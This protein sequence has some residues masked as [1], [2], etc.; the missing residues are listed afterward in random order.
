MARHRT[1]E[2]IVVG[3][4]TAGLFAGATAA[5]AGFDVVVLERKPTEEVGAIACGDAIKGSSAFPDVIDRDRLR[6][7]AFANTEIRRGVFEA[8]ETRMDVSLPTTGVV[9]DRKRY[10]EILADEAHRQGATI[11]YDTV[12][13]DVCQSDGVVRGVEA[14]RDGDPVTYRAPITIDATG[15]LSVLQDKADLSPA[16]F[17]TNVDYTQFCSAYREVIELEEPVDW[18]DA[19][20]FKPTAELGYLWYF[21][22]TPTRI[23]VGLGFR[24]DK[25][26]MELVDELKRDVRANSAFVGATVLNKAGAALPTRRPFDSAVAPGFMAVGDAAGHVNPTTGGGIVAAAKA[27]H[28]AATTALDAID[29]D[30]SDEEA[31]LWPYNHRVQT[32]FGKRF[33]ALDLYNIW[34][35]A[36][37]IDALTDVVTALPGERIVDVLRAGEASLGLRDVL[38]AI[39]GSVGNLDTLTDAYRVR[40]LVSEMRDHYETYP[41]TPSGLEAWQTERDTILQRA[42]AVTGADRKY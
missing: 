38:A 41:E 28:W 29:D 2:M 39:V 4:G 21:P 16:T 42:Y 40:S 6:A 27:G 10:G 26:P 8:G 25:E 31:A 35:G 22:R 37:D 11:H 30:S 20:V 3:A 19:L 14:I 12:V 32:G 5:A 1:Y 33:A 23:N 24:M 7:E 17:E 13:R 9:L 15:A 18:A 36:N 34:G